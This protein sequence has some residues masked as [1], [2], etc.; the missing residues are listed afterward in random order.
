MD[1]RNG[2]AKREVTMQNRATRKRSIVKAV[3]YRGI[4]VCL[5][6]LVVYLLTGKVMTA[7]AFMIVSNIYTTVA[8]FLHERV[9][10]G[11]KWGMEPQKEA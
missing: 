9:W 6:F 3:T 8:Y 5:D 11:I 2:G 7:A 4:I 1:T 10:A